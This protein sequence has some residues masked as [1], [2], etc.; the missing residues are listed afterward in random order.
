V[1]NNY[2]LI[3]LPSFDEEISQITYYIS[4]VLK[5][6]MATENLLNKIENAIKRRMLSPKSYEIYKRG[7]GSKYIWYRIYVGNFTIFY[8]VEDDVIELAH[9][10]YNKRDFDNLV[11]NTIII[12]YNLNIKFI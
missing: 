4:H 3:Y 10:I 11:W 12:W 8:I 1:K 7:K 5:N 9:I 2:K 6:S